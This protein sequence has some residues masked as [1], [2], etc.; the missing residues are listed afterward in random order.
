V[1]D[2]VIAIL[3]PEVPAAIVKAPESELIVGIDDAKVI[4]PTPLVTV[5]PE[6]A[7][8]VLN[9]KPDSFPINNWPLVGV[10]DKPVPPFNIG[11]M[12]VVS[13]EAKLIAPVDRADVPFLSIPF[14]KV[15]ISFR[16]DNS[17]VVIVLLA[18]IEPPLD[19]ITLSL[20]N[21]VELLVPPFAIDI[22]GKSLLVIALK[23][24][25][26]LVPSGEAKTLF[27]L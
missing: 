5:I 25:T 11:L 6:P 13:A 23:V 12:P 7:V 16:K 8:I 27:V 22:T 24:G 10:A 26:P 15:F 1:L 4:V 19:T 3:E 21:A 20:V 2:V 14:V 18:T 17:V 9:A